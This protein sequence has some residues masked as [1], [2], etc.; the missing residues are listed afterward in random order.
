MKFSGRSGESKENSSRFASYPS[1]LPNSN[2]GNPGSKVAGPRSGRP[3]PI[4]A[5]EPLESN[6]HSSGEKPNVLA[7]NRKGVSFSLWRRTPGPRLTHSLALIRR[8]APPSP[9]GRGTRP[10]LC[11]FSAAR[12][13]LNWADFRVSLHRGK[14]CPILFVKTFVR[15]EGQPVLYSMSI[16]LSP[17]KSGSL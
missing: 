8:S 17:Q 2:C 3:T 16:F 7:K 6:A 1:A 14:E 15:I 5:G 10:Q 12:S 4:S 13:Q 11:R 9:G